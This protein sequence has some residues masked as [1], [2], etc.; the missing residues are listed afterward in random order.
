MIVLIPKI[1]WY[2]NRLSIGQFYLVHVKL[3]FSNISTYRSIYLWPFGASFA[4]KLLDEDLLFQLENKI[5]LSFGSN[6]YVLA[7][8]LSKKISRS[9]VEGEKDFIYFF[10]YLQRCMIVFFLKLQWYNK[11]L[12]FDFFQLLHVKLLFSYIHSYIKLYIDLSFIHP[13]Y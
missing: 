3:T 2:N 6:P 1:Q 10:L 13:N 7:S 9:M 4:S 12:G 11:M 5:K 8:F